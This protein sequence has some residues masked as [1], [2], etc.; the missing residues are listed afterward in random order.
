MQKAK[1]EITIEK[2][3]LGPPKQVRGKLQ[4]G[5]TRFA[6][7]AY[8]YEHKSETVVLFTANVVDS[9]RST[10]IERFEDKVLEGI[11]REFKILGE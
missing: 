6:W 8:A 7:N 10:K 5:G 9:E 3:V 1:G 4:I 11:R 2:Q